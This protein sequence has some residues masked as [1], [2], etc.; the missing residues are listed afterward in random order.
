MDE[1]FGIPDSQL[2][3]AFYRSEPH[4][5]EGDATFIRRLEATRAELCCDEEASFNAFLPKL[6]SPFLD[7]LE[8]VRRARATYGQQEVDWT[9]L[10]KFSEDELSGMAITNA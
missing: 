9:L 2:K 8:S 1:Y 3:R 6:S 4:P 7:R 10:V 5:G